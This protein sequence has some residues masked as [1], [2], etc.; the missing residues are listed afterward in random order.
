MLIPDDQL[1]EILSA[2]MK[3]STSSNSEKVSAEELRQNEAAYRAAMNLY[4]STFSE[5]MPLMQALQLI[6]K[7][8]PLPMY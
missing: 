7:H 2:G 5:P 4:A 3:S 8:W 1:T 6:R